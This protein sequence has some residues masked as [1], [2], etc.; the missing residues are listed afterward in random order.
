MTIRGPYGYTGGWNTKTG[1]YDCP[2]DS[3]VDA[4]NV[5]LVNGRLA[6]CK[7]RKLWSGGIHPGGPAQLGFISF[8]NGLLVVSCSNKIATIASTFSGGGWTDITGSVTWTPTA[9]YDW[10]DSLNNILVKGGPNTVP[11]QWTG[12]GNCSA[13]GGSPPYGAN[14]GCTCNNYFFMANNAS[15]P[16]RV[17]WSNIVDPN[18]WNVANY[19]D[20]K[21]DA[22]DSSVTALYPFGED[23]LI[24]KN[25]CIARFYTNQLSGTLGPLVILTEKFG[26]AGQKCVARL[27]D[28]RVVFVGYN[29]HVYIYDGNTFLDIS[30]QPYP[31]SNIQSVFNNLYFKTAGIVQ[32]GICVYQGKNQVWISYPHNWT[33][34]IGTAYT[35]G[36]IIKYDYIMNA[37]LSPIVSVVSYS[38]INY[39]TSNT[40]Y[41]ISAG[42]VNLFQED[43]D[44]GSAGGVGPFDTFVTKTIAFGADE[45]EFTPRSLV[46]PI[47]SQVPGDNNF[48]GALYYGQ[49][50]Y[51]NPVT[52]IGFNYNT[53]LNPEYKKVFSLSSKSGGWNT[54]QFKFDEAF[55]NKPFTLS[56]FYLSDQIEA[57][58]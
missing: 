49:N 22:P 29:N 18:T 23:L 14:A 13:L 20:V 26:C 3:Y 32:G 36:I 35:G 7:G 6:Q 56:P 57:Q 43:T 5:E 15:F 19:V 38:L 28:G 9:G 58:V 24:F 45:K 16:H 31:N 47:S 27:P 17:W 2:Q 12:T 4:L 48:I 54:G 1:P 40:E 53:S 30:D 41:L 21:I 10:A 33:S 8:F 55:S 34:P 25:N 52:Y 37:W 50:G 42:V 11:I 46:W 39:I 51:N 44:L